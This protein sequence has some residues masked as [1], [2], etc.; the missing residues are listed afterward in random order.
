MDFVAEEVTPVQFEPTGLNT[1]LLVAFWS[2]LPV[3]KNNGG[4][5]KEFAE[6]REQIPKSHPRLKWSA[7]GVV[8]NV[9]IEYD[10]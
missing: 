9:L 10:P 1:V 6:R 7:G 2:S 5:W 3:E 8:G 4:V